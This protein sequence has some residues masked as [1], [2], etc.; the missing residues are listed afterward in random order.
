[1]IRYIINLDNLYDGSTVDAQ[2]HA[3]SSFT[4][5][6]NNE[7]SIIFLCELFFLMCRPPVVPVVSVAKT[8]F[9]KCFKY[10]P[11]WFLAQLVFF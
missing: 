7:R 2:Q 6:K 11:I 9:F 1:M 4:N 3:Y 10:R 8:S 5:L